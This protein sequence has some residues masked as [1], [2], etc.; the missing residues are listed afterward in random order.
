M[1]TLEGLP[2][3]VHR[4]H[5]HSSMYYIYMEGMKQGGGGSARGQEV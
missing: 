1:S 3:S 4:L 2:D 5:F